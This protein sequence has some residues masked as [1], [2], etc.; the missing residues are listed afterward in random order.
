[1]ANKSY[2]PNIYGGQDRTGVFELGVPAMKLSEYDKFKKARKLVEKGEDK[3]GKAGNFITR[4]LGR[5]AEAIGVGRNE[6]PEKE[7]TGQPDGGNE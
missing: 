2:N 7:G 1:M 4:M 5:T 6:D 3:D